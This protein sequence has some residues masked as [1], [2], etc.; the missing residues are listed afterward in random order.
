MDSMQRL[1]DADA[2]TRLRDHDASLF[3]DDP[4]VQDVVAKRL[5]WTT[6]ASEAMDTS[7]EFASSLGGFGDISDVVL[8]GMGGSSLA[9]LVM[10]SV[11]GHAPDSPTL[12]V[13]D[14]TSPITV[15]E[16]LEHIDLASA[17]WITASKS[18]STIEPNTLYALFRSIVDPVLGAQEAGKRFIAITDPGSPLEKLAAEAGFGATILAPSDVGGRYS[19][20]SVFGLVPSHLTGVDVP[21]LVD[22]ARYAE[23][24]VSTLP[25]TGN[26]A[27]Q[28]A[29]FLADGLADGRDKLTLVLPAR[30]RSFGLWVEQLVAESLGKMGR[31]VV[32]VIELADEPDVAGYSP[33]RLIAVVRTHNDAAWAEGIVAQAGNA[34]V[35]ET[36]LADEYDVGAAFVT[37]EWATALVGFLIGVNPFDE[38][39][40]AAAKTATAHVLEG[41][42]VVNPEQTSVGGLG[43][44]FFGRPLKG[45]EAPEG[46]ER[47]LRAALDSAVEGDYIAILAYVPE[48]PRVLSELAGAVADVTRKTG[49]PICL[50][51]GP[52]YLHSTGQLHKGGPNEGVFVVVTANDPFDFAVPGSS[53]TLRTL[54]RA[55]SSGDVATLA[56]RDRRVVTVV[57]PDASPDSAKWFATELRSAAGIGKG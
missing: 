21:R 52:R 57:L 14:T 30:L 2:I 48:S 4:D 32:P 15:A 8:L 37:W 50:E 35:H 19:A 18:G 36:V 22:K 44:G 53:W 1:A 20:L 34:P 33:D 29:A 10:G 23:D 27:A 24:S 56:E 3:S 26:P 13:L 11:L 51:L 25:P 45:P 46:L 47:A 39:D 42:L 5:G 12:H 16:A 6:L 7:G 55:Q 41:Q 38:P 31:G 49:K 17:V 9:A 43:L 28:L 54:H 40:V